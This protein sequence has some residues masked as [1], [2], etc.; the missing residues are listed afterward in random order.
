MDLHIIDITFLYSSSVVEELQ[1]EQEPDS[2]NLTV[3]VKAKKLP[4]F[5]SIN[6]TTRGDQ[7]VD[8]SMQLTIGNSGQTK[9]KL[10][11]SKNEY[12]TVKKFIQC[13]HCRKK[14]LQGQF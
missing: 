13:V 6:K 3:P 8:A 14:Y 7:N 1:D 11:L 4:A 9:S 10:F 12:S 2:E 5:I